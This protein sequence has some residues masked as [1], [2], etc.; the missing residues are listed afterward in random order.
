MCALDCIFPALL[1]ETIPVVLAIFI[2][3]LSLWIVLIHIKYAGISL[4][5]KMSLS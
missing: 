2:F 5:L 3:S 4:I 1:Q